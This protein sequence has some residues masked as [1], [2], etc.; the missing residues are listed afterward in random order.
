[1][2]NQSTTGAETKGPRFPLPD[3]KFALVVGYSRVNQIVVGKIA[4]RSGLKV[5]SESPDRARLV[6]SAKEPGVVIIDAGADDKEWDHLLAPLAERRSERAQ[7]LPFVIILCSSPHCPRVADNDS[8]FDS[9]VVKPITP[10][11]L[12]PVIESL[13]VRISD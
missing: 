7:K 4:E 9:V 3:P 1:M 10:E 8:I 2:P 12:Q 5:L 6:L 13:L 11:R